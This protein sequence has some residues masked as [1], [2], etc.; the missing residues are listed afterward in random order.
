MKQAVLDG[1][2]VLRF[3]TGM[4][5]DGRALGTVLAAVLPTGPQ[6]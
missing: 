6:R 3:T 5:R 2:R 4:V 1:W